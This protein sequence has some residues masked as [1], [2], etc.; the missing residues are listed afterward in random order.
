M[1]LLLSILFCLSRNLIL[2]REAEDPQCNLEHW[3]FQ[4]MIFFLVKHLISYME[5]HFEL[6]SFE[7]TVVN[8][9][10]EISIPQIFESLLYKS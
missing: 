1:C 4:K 7:K 2:S 6:F 10:S 8:L 9:L 5:Y 3:K